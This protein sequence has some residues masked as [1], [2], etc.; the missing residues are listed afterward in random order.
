MKKLKLNQNMGKMVKA[1]GFELDPTQEYVINIKSE[2]EEQSAILMSVQTM[3]LAALRDYH[4]WLT[5]NGFNANMPNPTNAS[6]APFYGKR[7]L[8]K[9]DL[10]QGI[11]VKSEEDEDYYII[12]ECSRLNEGFKYT[13]IIVT[14]GGCL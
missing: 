11:V 14:L 1:N 10:S 6:V 8:W 4:N 9:T 5:K 13:Q 12:L 3:G 7:C 2:L